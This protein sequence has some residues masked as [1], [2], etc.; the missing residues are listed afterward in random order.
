M[1]KELTKN[2]KELE[3][4]RDIM[5]DEILKLKTEKIDALVR[6]TAEME[7][8]MANS[9]TRAAI[10]MLQ[11]KEEMAGGD[12]SNWDVAGWK[13][14]ISRLTGLETEEKVEEK[15]DDGEQTKDVGATSGAGV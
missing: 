7:E 6:H 10:A 2:I 15:A 4:E 1:N 3:D 9:K 11:A 14:A 12:P 13:N 8:A 5:D